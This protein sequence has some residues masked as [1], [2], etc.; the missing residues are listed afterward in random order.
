[1]DKIDYKKEF[2]SLYSPPSK[3]VAAVDVPAFNFIMVDGKG[4]PNT[5]QEYREAV[6]ALFTVS[7][8]LKFMVKKGEPAVDYGVL[9]LEGLWW[10]EEMNSFATGDKASWMWTAMIMQPKFVTNSL[11]REAVK[12][13][14]KK[15]D[16]PAVGKLRFEAFKEG[17]SAQIMHI[18]PYSA[19]KTT[20]EKIHNYIQTNGYEFNG[21]HHEIYLG[22]PRKAAPEKMKTILRQPIKKK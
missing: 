11:L 21:K 2:K 15:K 22:D 6:E 19:E 4:D 12:Q 3:E 17:L 10:A 16:L 5:S 20:I 9:P 14:K 7:Y 18:G 8:A 1:M 13:T